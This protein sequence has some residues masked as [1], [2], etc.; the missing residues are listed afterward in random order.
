[1]CDNRTWEVKKGE[2]QNCGG[3]GV[4]FFCGFEN[5][6]VILQA[7]IQQQELLIITGGFYKFNVLTNK[8]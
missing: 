7:Q 5:N 8:A 1:M 6:V 4:R 3:M 2:G